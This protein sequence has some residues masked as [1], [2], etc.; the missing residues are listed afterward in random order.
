MSER[1]LNSLKLH[2]NAP[3][4]VWAPL[5]CPNFSRYI[6]NI[7]I[8]LL[9]PARWYLPGPYKICLVNPLEDGVTDFYSVP[10][11]ERRALDTPPFLS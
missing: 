8:P 1:R 3:L 9:S 7:M 6:Q 4:R 11:R 10:F 5:T 2:P